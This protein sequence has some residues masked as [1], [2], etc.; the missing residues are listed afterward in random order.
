MKFTNKH[1]LSDFIYSVLTNDKYKKVGDYSVTGLLKPVRQVI[2]EERHDDEISMDISELAYSALG[3]G[4]HS[5]FEIDTTGDEDRWITEQRFVST[6][7]GKKVSGQIDLFDKKEKKI[8]DYKVCSVWKYMFGDV[9]DWTKQIN[10][11]AY[12][13]NDFLKIK[14]ESASV[15]AIFR[16]WKFDEYERDLSNNPFSPTYPECPIKEIEI[17]I[18]PPDEVYNSI[19]EKV[20]KFESAKLLDDDS[21]PLCTPDE[22]W[23]RGEAWA[24]KKK[25]AKRAM[26]GGV[27]KTEADAHTFAKSCGVPVDIEHRIAKSIRCQRYCNAAPFCNQWKEIQTTTGE[28]VG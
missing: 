10:A 27:C 14:V 24:V 11:Y 17:K 7:A 22:R 1:G 3:T 8:Q 6:I 19:E 5:V 20:K 23:A 9:A 26:N 2:L 21:L 15:I 25:G 13:I 4:V 16:D 18:Y 28:L 12:M